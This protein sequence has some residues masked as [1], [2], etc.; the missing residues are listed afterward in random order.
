MNRF[1]KQRQRCSFERDHTVL[2]DS[3]LAACCPASTL[4]CF[5]CRPS[6]QRKA[7]GVQSGVPRI[8]L[9]LATRTWLS[10]LRGWG[11]GNASLFG[12]ISNLNR[13][14]SI[15]KVLR[16]GKS[17]P[18]S[19]CFTV[20]KEREKN[21]TEEECRHRSAR[22]ESAGRR[23]GNALATMFDL[24]AACSSAACLSTAWSAWKR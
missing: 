24:V 13:C 1:F 11:G 7:S 14:E 6:L 20:A 18:L 5:V 17:L 16:F 2:S 10:R 8:P 22:M 9:R 23:R 3:L 4:F 15:L 19:G 21:T 12:D